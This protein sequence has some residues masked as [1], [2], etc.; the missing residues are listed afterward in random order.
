MLRRMVVASIL[1]ASA[2]N[3]QYVPPVLKGVKG[4]GTPR[5]TNGPIPF[6]AADE[7]W[8]LARSKHFVFIS[9]ADE[10]RTR[11]VA[12]ELET[13][14]SALTQVDSTFS[15]PTATPTRVILFTRRGESRPYFDMLLNRRDANVSGVF[16]SQRDCGSMLINQDYSWQGR[17]RA[18][19]HELVHYLMQSGDAHAPLWLEEG[20]AEYFS[21][22][23]IRARSV[24]AGEPISSH[25]SIL[26]QRSRIPLTE[27]F[28]AVRESD[29]YNVSTGQTVFYAE[30]WAIVDWL[31]RTSRHNGGDFYAFVHDL[32]HGGTV[33][34]ALK[35]HY[36]RTLQDIDAALTRYSSAQ[37]AAWAITLA[38][39]ATD[40]NVTV[41]PLDRASTLYELGHFLS[42]LE[43]LAADAE[44]HYR[45]ALDVNPRHARALAGLGMLRAASAKYAE[46]TEFFEKAAAADPND[47]EVGLS[48]AEALM[49]DQIGA[50]AQST[51]TS[52]DDITRFRKARTLAQRALEHR[53]DPAF[54]LGRALGDLG[55]T[56]SVED[57]VTPGIAALEEAST[58]LPGRTDFALHLLAMY[59]RIGDRAKADPLF[60]RLDAAHKPQVS[61][62]ARAVIVRAELTRANA[63]THDGRLDDAAAVV[64]DLAA[65][66]PDLDSRRDYENKAAELTRVAAQNRQIEAYNKIVAQVNNG[67]YHDATKALAEFL[68]TASD[69]DIVRDAKKLQKRL[70]EYQP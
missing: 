26:R 48:Y 14:A 31:V 20:I 46:A 33:E 2:A 18:P 19:L 43:E 61:F 51:D 53:A 39:P 38:V 1:I 16:V 40:T 68:T 70:S 58:L 65:N 56:Y 29:V 22:S 11:S 4:D 69:P 8:L 3:A 54:P 63:L 7:K 13:L 15:A 47:V 35:M 25:I 67:N 24:S 6:P 59:R 50:L 42:G 36:H 44:R 57:D 27:L 60:A 32:A 41:E 9:S 37:R 62:A 45:A 28:A 17:E 21:N 64:R 49:Q 23:M 5:Q 30:S 12:A 10:K 55:T 52:D 66:T 34:T